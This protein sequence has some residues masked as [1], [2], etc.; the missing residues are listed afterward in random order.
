MTVIFQLFCAEDLQRLS[1]PQ[2][3]ELRTTVADALGLRTNPPCR[4][5]RGASGSSSGSG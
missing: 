5:A 2:L 4:T 1:R 3:T